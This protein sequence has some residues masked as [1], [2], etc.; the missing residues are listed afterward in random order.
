MPVS[1]HFLPK[2]ILFDC[3]G[4]LLL[5]A[6]LHFEA[7]AEAALAQGADMPRDWYMSLTGLGRKDLFAHFTK[8]FGLSLDVPRLIQDSIAMTVALAPRATE[9]RWRAMRAPRVGVPSHA[10]VSP[11]PSTG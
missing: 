10:F 4:T 5:T 3:D 2:A 11:A 1:P 9:I 7:I 8:D 6:D